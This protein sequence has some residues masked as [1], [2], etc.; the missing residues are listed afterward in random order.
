[1]DQKEAMKR[2][3]EDTCAKLSLFAFEIAQLPLVECKPVIDMLYRDGDDALFKELID[4]AI[5]LK[6]AVLAAEAR[7]GARVSRR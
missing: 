4:A 2:I 5:P 6:L 1:M 7:R 3:V